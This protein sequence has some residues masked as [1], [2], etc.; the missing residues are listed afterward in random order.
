MALS[1]R[2]PSMASP[3]TAS[4]TT[5]STSAKTDQ[6]IT[7][8]WSLFTNIPLSQTHD[9]VGEC[10]RPRTGRFRTHPP[11]T[12][13]IHRR[14]AMWKRDSG[15]TTGR[16]NKHQSSEILSK[17]TSDGPDSSTRH[18]LHPQADC[19]VEEGP[20]EDDEGDVLPRRLV[21]RREAIEG[22]MTVS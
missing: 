17:D 11:V 2:P 4:P 3:T 15:K 6:E 12:S 19:N 20:R 9:S 14:I 1:T 18:L 7:L 22:K 13:S 21:A 5:A 16:P 8:K 10:P